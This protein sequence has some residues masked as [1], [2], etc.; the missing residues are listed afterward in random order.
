MPQ[1]LK[2]V[3]RVRG[4]IPKFATLQSFYHLGDH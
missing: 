1:C 2:R 4:S 3:L